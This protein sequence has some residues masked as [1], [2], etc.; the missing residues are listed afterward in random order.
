MPRL[1]S[2]N[3]LGLSLLPSIASAA[4]IFYAPPPPEEN[5]PTFSGEAELG[6]TQLTGNTDSQTLLG[7]SRLTWLTSRYWTH[8]LRGEVRHVT[9]DGDTSAEQYLIS[10]R[11]RYDFDGPHYLFGFA[12][13]EKDRFSGYDQQFTTIGGYGRHVIDRESHRLSLEAGP[14]YR[15]DR[16]EDEENNNLG[17]VYS[18]LD[19]Q[20]TL[21]DS[22]YVRQEMSVEAT[23][24][25]TTSRSVSSLTARLNSRLSLRLSHEIKHNSD[26][27][28]TADANTDQTTNATLLYTW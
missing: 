1:L 8:T 7:K 19:Y 4:G 24:A 28:E 9:R 3:A 14:G 12:R 17:V 5:S 18:A 16:I 2:W 10:G 20:W 26:P 11:E 23:D 13:W 21:S 6:Y 25:N 22:S 27:P 15:H